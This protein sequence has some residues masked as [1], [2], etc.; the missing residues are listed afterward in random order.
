MAT[1]KS[2]VLIRTFSAGVHFG[3]LKSRKGQEVVLQKARRIWSW[4]G[5]NTLHELS[6]SGCGEGSRLSAPVPEITLTQAI[7]VIP[8]SAEASKRLAAL[9]WK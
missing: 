7:E 6:Q 4:K 3:T 8:M 5:A 1:K 2:E 9:G